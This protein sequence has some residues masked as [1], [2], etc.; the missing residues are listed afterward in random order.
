V[1]L[2][3]VLSAGEVALGVNGTRTDTD[4]TFAFA[5][6]PPGRYRV[7]SVVPGLSPLWALKSARLNGHDALDEAFEVNGA[8]LSGLTITL[9]DQITQIN[10]SLEDATGRPAPDYYVIVFPVDQKYWT[11]NSRRIKTARPGNDGKYIIRGL[12]AGTYRIGA[13]T[14]VESNDWFEPWFLQQ[15]LPASAEVTLG[16]GERKIFPLKIGG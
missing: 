4:Q 8:D 3:P 14:D 15:L 5:G 12:P 2:T 13:V 16:E 6:V 1:N 11:Q 9:T 10:G 7:N